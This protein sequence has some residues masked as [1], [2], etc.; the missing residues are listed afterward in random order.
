MIRI[1]QIRSV[2]SGQFARWLDLSNNMISVL[3]ESVGNLQQLQFLGTARTSG[4]SGE[5]RV[6]CEG[7][8]EK[9]GLED[10]I[11]IYILLHI[12]LILAES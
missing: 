10:H 4:P 5:D 9:R 8:D 3:P 1:F 11:Y 6:G 12:T 2:L 7:I